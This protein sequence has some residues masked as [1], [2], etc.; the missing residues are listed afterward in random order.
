MLFSQRPTPLC[1]SITVSNAA[2]PVPSLRG[3]QGAVAPLT[4]ACAPHFVLLKIFFGAL[5]NDKTTDNNGKRNDN[6]LA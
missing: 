3:G 4:T 5:R 6:V 1:P 2:K